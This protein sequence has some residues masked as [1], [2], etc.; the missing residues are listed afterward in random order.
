MRDGRNRR[1]Q[2][3]LLHVQPEGERDEQQ[4]RAP[5]AGAH[6]HI[7]PVKPPALEHE[8]GDGVFAHRPVVEHLRHAERA[9][10]LRGGV[11]AQQRGDEPAR[12]AQRVDLVLHPAVDGGHD[13]LARGAG[14]L[15]APGDAV[16]PAE[17]AVGVV[18]GRD[19]HH[20]PVDRRR[21]VLGDHGGVE[22]LVF[23]V[24][25]DG[26][27]AARENPRRQQRA[28][29]RARGLHGQRPDDHRGDD[30]DGRRHLDLPADE[31]HQPAQ[32]RAGKAAA[33]GFRLRHAQ[34]EVERENHERQ[35]ERVRVEH[36]CRQVHRK[37][38]REHHQQHELPAH[39][40][41]P[42]GDQKQRVH[43]QQIEQRLEHDAGIEQVRD[44]QRHEGPEEA[45]EHQHGAP[46]VGKARQIQPVVRTVEIALRGQHLRAVV[47]H[48][49]VAHR[50]VFHQIAQ[51]QVHGKQREQECGPRDALDARKPLH[52]RAL[53]PRAHEEEQRRRQHADDS[54][55]RRAVAVAGPGVGQ[56]DDV[57]RRRRGGQKRQSHAEGQQP[58]LH[59]P[60]LCRR[61]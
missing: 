61:S 20:D 52:A 36:G 11:L 37:A 29:R 43:G 22:H 5:Y 23:H 2:V 27:R 28:Q 21:V 57:H 15:H 42:A 1:A 53:H 38:Q 55:D 10:P 45:R 48:V 17:P 39:A 31:G 50:R 25:V 6:A 41:Q 49:V 60:S 19:A 40:A 30:H 12:V 16:I 54:L 24:D 8:G 51:Q 32:R 35:R 47:E 14:L 46:L 13:L 4:V 44:A 59:A 58:F 7:Q 9:V 3:A 33:R 34:R 26:L 18:A 56:Q